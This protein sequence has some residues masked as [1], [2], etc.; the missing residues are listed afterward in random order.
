M[1]KKFGSSSR[2]TGLATEGISAAEL[3]SKKFN[4]NISD[5]NAEDIQTLGEEAGFSKRDIR[6][7]VKGLEHFQTN[8]NADIVFNQSG[9]R[10]NTIFKTDAGATPQPTSTRTT[11]MRDKTTP[12]RLMG[13][14]RNVN[15]LAGLTSTLI[16]K[17]AP[18]TTS[19]VSQ[20]GDKPK[21]GD[22]E[23]LKSG[24]NEPP[25]SGDGDKPKSGD[26]NTPPTEPK[27]RPSVKPTKVQIPDLLKRPESDF[28]GEEDAHFAHMGKQLSDDEF[29]RSR[30]VYPAESLFVENAHKGMGYYGNVLTQ[31]SYSPAK[32]FN[33]KLYDKMIQ[34]KKTYPYKNRDII[35]SDAFKELSDERKAEIVN[36][37]VTAFT[38]GPI[39]KGITQLPQLTKSA[40]NLIKNKGFQQAA[41]QGFNKAASFFKSAPKTSPVKPS[42]PVT[43]AAKQPLGLPEPKISRMARERGVNYN[44]SSGQ[45]ITTPTSQPVTSKELLGLPKAQ[46]RPQKPIMGEYATKAP[47]TRTE[48]RR[49]IAADK[50]VKQ[51]AAQ[52]RRNQAQ[53]NAN[54]KRTEEAS[55]RMAEE[56][57]MH[58]RKFGGILPK[59]QFGLQ[60]AE[61]AGQI[62][63]SGLYTSESMGGGKS[64]NKFDWGNALETG[65]IVGA[66]LLASTQKMPKIKMGPV[67][68]VN[69]RTPVPSDLPK[70]QVMNVQPAYDRM[71]AD[72]R[73]KLM[74]GNMAEAQ[75]KQIQNQWQTQNALQKRQTAAQAMEMQNK[76]DM[77]N[78]QMAAEQAGRKSYFDWQ[79]GAQ[80][81]ANKQQGYETAFANLV[82]RMR[83]GAADKA[84]SQ[85]DMAMEVLKNPERYGPE[86]VKSAQQY[87]NS[88]LPQPTKEPTKGKKGMKL[89]AA[90]LLRK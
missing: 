6:R 43:P 74:Y 28:T 90:N 19:T 13:L 7:A 10:F 50:Y 33:Q 62:S 72:S 25:K 86:N 75:N 55:R 29:F 36:A 14:G 85:R 76:A 45:T 47:K 31:K 57:G 82:D 78:A 46:P 37:A 39:A 77:F 9:K 1:A 18:T 11:G 89:K 84:Q 34:L 54:I 51:K 17:S 27:K 44:P 21:S 49:E 87:F 24:D 48:I 65:L 64:Q 4:K 41:K 73:E 67:Q 22:N 59:G 81:F 88:M 58:M 16:G 3:L 12:A 61:T 60:L 68:K 35:V 32:E 63:R 5:V 38:A 20:D 66:P 70:P 23:S 52:A 79:T 56:G 26:L 42:A 83:Y 71:T 2:K 69:F 30:A 80:N 8:E 53:I 40:Y 15:Y